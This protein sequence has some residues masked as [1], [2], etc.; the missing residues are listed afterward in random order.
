MRLPA[1][2]FAIV[3]PFAVHAQ[4]DG[5][6][7]DSLA[8]FMAPGVAR[9]LAEH[10]AATLGDVRYALELDLTHPDTARG[11]VMVRVNRTGGGDLI[12]DFRGPALDAIRV[13]DVAAQVEFNGAHIRVP[14]GALRDGAN[15][16]HL[17]FRTRI[18][19]AG[20]SIIKYQDTGDGNTY[21]YTLLV[22]A[23]ANLLFPSFDQPDL[24]ARVSLTL[25]TPRGWK[26]VANG[27][28]RDTTASGDAVVHRFAESEPISTYL[29]AFA[30]GPWAVVSSPT[31]TRPVNLFVRRSRVKEV[32]GD[33]LIA[34]N[35]R[36]LDW[37]EG[38]FARPFP[39]AKYDMVLAPA[40]PFGGMEHPGAV[41]YN[42]DGF[43]FRERP[44]LTQRLG[45]QATTFH[46]VAHQWFGDLVT[47][48]WFDDLWLKEGFATYMAAKMQDAL[49]P[50]AN[51][52]KTF[53]LRNKPPAYAVDATTGTTPVW[54]ELAN[55]DQAKSN[56]GAIVYNKAPSVLKQL[57][58]LVGDSAF[59]A[60]VRAFLQRHEYGN[61]TWRELLETIGAA[62]GRPLED[63]GAQYILRPGMPVLEQRP[64][65]D[66][67]CARCIGGVTLVQRP[68]RPLAGDGVWPMRV[69]VLFGDAGGRF[70]RMPVEIA[71]ET[72]VVR[73]PAGAPPARFVFANSRDFGY[74]LIA[75]DSASAGWL[76]D[77]I[78][79]IRDDFLRAMLWGALWD[80]VR[81]ARLP[82]RR[83]VEE[84]LGVLPREPDEQLVAS[85]LGRMSRAVSAYFSDAE[86]AAMRPALERTLWAGAADTA[87]SYGIRKAHLDAFIG[88][89]ESREALTRLD[90]LLDEDTAAG[91]PLR[92]P[93]RWAIIG[94][95]IE[96]GSPLAATRLTTEERRDSTTEGRRRAFAARAAAPNAA[97]KAE[98]FRRYFADASLNEEWATAS[99]GNFNSPSQSALTLPYLV[100]ALDSLQW[101]QANRRIFYLGSWLGAFLGGQTSAEALSRVD[102][103]L[104]EHPDLPIDL[105]RKI[106]QAADELRRTVAIRARYAGSDAR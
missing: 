70:T 3:V 68:A 23:D 92:S 86:R 95:L 62:A 74:G 65:A 29:I 101:I 46:E 30:A 67:R 35:Q 55:L 33:T 24:K 91:G 98:Y 16:I 31:G 76:L 19:A 63:W 57:N 100:P 28:L 69:E 14:A 40:F 94:T 8:S 56:Y 103:F 38:Y 66:A 43:I 9:E 22:P 18:A 26:A 59:Q 99:L 60:G 51:A 71:A 85:V 54:Q 77:S 106:L 104:A 53:Y 81:D 75:L 10:R 93:T 42:E 80:M 17:E 58:Y 72:T 87:R 13:N 25:R 105:R 82:P 20:A 2:A 73:L 88:L 4:G 90:S 12:L 84:A 78:G 6:A 49:S 44:T 7:P 83:W 96:R 11:A 47:M 97:V 79:S 48:R 102:A 45:R 61:A 39:F 15:A 1:L 27:P 36:A 37:L 64:L 41:F 5:A 21:L 32:D 50:D 52:W 34:M 89:A